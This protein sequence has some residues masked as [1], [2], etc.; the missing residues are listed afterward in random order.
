VQFYYNQELVQAIL[1]ER[2]IEFLAEGN[3]LMDIQVLLADAAFSAEESKA[4]A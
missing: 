3:A 1:N 2:R 4:S